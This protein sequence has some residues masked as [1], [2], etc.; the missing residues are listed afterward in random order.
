MPAAIVPLRRKAALFIEIVIKP[1]LQYLTVRRGYPRFP[2][3]ITDNSQAIKAKSGLSP[4]L[5]PIAA[6]LQHPKAIRQN[7]LIGYINPMAD[8]STLEKNFY[9]MLM[10]S[11]HWP[12]AQL[13]EYQQSQLSQLLEHARKNVPF[14][15]SRLDPVFA[16]SGRIDWSRWEE[17]PILTRKDLIDHRESMLASAV[18]AGHG[19]TRNY[20]SSGTTGLPVAVRHNGLAFLASRAALYRSNS[21]HKVDWSKPSCDCTRGE[22]TF[23]PWPDGQL[24]NRWGPA[25]DETAT[26]RVWHINR[27]ASPEQ[28]VRFMQEK[29][30]AYLGSRPKT[31]QAAALEALRLKL[32]LKLDA[33]LGHGTGIT[34]EESED[35]RRAFGARIIGVYSSTECHK[36]AHP[37][38]ATGRYHVNAE[39]VLVEIVNEAGRAS[40]VGTPGRV[41]M[42][43][44]LSTAQP[45]IRYDQGDTAIAGEQCSCGRTLPVLERI[46][47]R[48]AQ[49]FRM[50]DGRRLSPSVPPLLK[51][52]LGTD[53]WQI[54]QVEPLVFE[55]RYVEL[56]PAKPDAKEQVIQN[57]LSQLGKSIEV[58][59]VKL[60]TLPLTPSGKF[61]ENV[62]ELP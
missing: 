7:A 46:V 32:P 15:K 49:L 3:L 5:R 23:A 58:R 18:P 19:E 41:V 12:A 1:T 60:D 26:G 62:C 30:V 33:V 34:E 11:Q 53:N 52:Q 37:C 39:I 43:P 57:M 54:A 14:Y 29:G 31:A 48:T 6:K 55:I 59:F 44:L 16:Q 56:R 13:L 21:W 61:M 51:W 24:G 42:T 45:L 8:P 40:A 10:K 9:E 47:G 25:W 38:P 35:C 22:P 36:V 17:I 2:K 20:W 27:Q 50:P 4:K 28:L